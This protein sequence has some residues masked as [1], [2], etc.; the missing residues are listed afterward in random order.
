VGH[1]DQPP[2]RYQAAPGT[3]DIL[4]LPRH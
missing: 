4:G 1:L 2:G 3:S